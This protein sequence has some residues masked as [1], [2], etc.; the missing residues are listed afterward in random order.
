MGRW[1]MMSDL[2]VLRELINE[3]A[4]VPLVDAHYGKKTVV[5]DETGN[6]GE[7]QY[8]IRI[9]GIPNDAVVVKTNMFPS[10][11]NIFACRKGECNRSDYVVVANS[12]AGAFIVHIEMKKGRKLAHDIIDQL[13]GAECFISYCRAI[14]CRFWQRPHFLDQYENRFVAFREVQT[15]KS[16]TRESRAPV[17]HDVPERMLR[18]SDVRNGREI[19]FRRLIQGGSHN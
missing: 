18:I 1:R 11:R 6:Q 3:K 10:P 12:E 16:R 4:L 9:K 19:T 14:V 7:I 13:K 15:S 8:S 2:D 17:L 5:L